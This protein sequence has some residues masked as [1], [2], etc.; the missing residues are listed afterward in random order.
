MNTKDTSNLILAFAIN[1]DIQ[2]MRLTNSIDKSYNRPPSYSENYFEE[3]AEE[4]RELSKLQKV[5]FN[6]F[7]PFEYILEEGKR[8]QLVK[9]T[10]QFGKNFI[11]DGVFHGWGCSYEE[12][13]SGPGNNSYALVETTEGLIEE[14]LP[15]NIKFIKE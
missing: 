1:A 3:K 5:R 11:H 14:V 12:F 9:G 6:K 8:R 4:L 2:S 7:I 13:E 15:C 10:G